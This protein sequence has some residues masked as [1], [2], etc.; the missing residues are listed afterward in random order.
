MNVQIK[1]ID[2]NLPL[3]EYATAG[4]CGFDI[5]SRETMTVQPKEIILAP[6][7]LIIATPPGYALFVAPRSSLAR[8]KGLG[9][10]H[11]F[12]IVDQDYCGEKDELLIQL[13]NISD[14]EVTIKRGERIAQ[15]LFVRIDTAQWQEVE[16]MNDKSRG[17][18]GSTDPDN[19]GNSKSTLTKETA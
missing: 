6:S 17:G 9:M 7:N 8:K 19:N 14:S 15:G 13:Q 16:K 2:P 10:P 18:F 1:R 4:S 12:G 11:S 3:P 5:Y